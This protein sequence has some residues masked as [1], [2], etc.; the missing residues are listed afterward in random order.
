MACDYI[1]SAPILFHIDRSW[2]RLTTPE[3]FADIM[4]AAVVL[5]ILR[6]TQSSVIHLLVMLLDILALLVVLWHFTAVDLGL[7]TIACFSSTAHLPLAP[8]PAPAT[9]ATP[10]A[11]LVLSRVVTSAVCFGRPTPSTFSYIRRWG[12]RVLQIR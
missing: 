3:S 1:V 5:L 4:L 2:A 7:R 9:A 10:A 6:T 12:P 11:G 8:A